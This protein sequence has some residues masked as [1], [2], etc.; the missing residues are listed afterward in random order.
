MTLGLIQQNERGAKFHPALQDLT[1]HLALWRCRWLSFALSSNCWR[2]L[3]AVGAHTMTRARDV[4]A[5][6]LAFAIFSTNSERTPPPAAQISPDSS[7]VRSTRGCGTCHGPQG[8]SCC[9]PAGHGE[10]LLHV[11]LRCL[12]AA[13]AAA[14]GVWDS[15]SLARLTHQLAL[16]RPRWL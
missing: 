9:S 7:G 16:W 13:E 14:H 4:H 8:M 1:H 11:W 2:T 15:I 12:R 10:C 5:T 6:W 3:W